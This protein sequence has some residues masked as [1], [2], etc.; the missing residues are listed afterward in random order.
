M[1]FGQT[2]GELLLR[3]SELE[4]QL[5]AKADRRAAQKRSHTGVWAAV[6][7]ALVEADRPLSVRVARDKG[8]TR[9]YVDGF[10]MYLLT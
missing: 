10:P 4:E 6:R 3:I 2:I 5:E 9:I 1:N 7:A 8:I